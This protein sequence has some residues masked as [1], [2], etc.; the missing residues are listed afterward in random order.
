MRDLFKQTAIE[1]RLLDEAKERYEASLETERSAHAAVETSK[2]QRMAKEAQIEKADADVLATKAEADVA[3]ADWERSK[4]MVEFATIYPTFDGKVTQRSLFPGD[5]VRAASS[6]THLPLLTIERTDRF[7]I[8]VQIP[9]QDAPYADDNDPAFVKL[10]AL[11]GQ[12]FK[13]KISRIAGAEDPQI[14]LMR[15]EIDLENKTG[16]IRPGMYGKAI[17][18]LEKSNDPMTMPLASLVGPT[19]DNR[20]QVYV[21]RG[22][23]AVLVPVELGMSNGTRIGVRGGLTV[24]D[25]VIRNP[26]RN[27]QNGMT[28]EAEVAKATPN[29]S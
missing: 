12:V 20:G 25:Q 26:G 29:L 10:D 9:D 13:A 8:V 24:Q 19:K 17:I 21:V 2:A 14:R 16:K 4:V 3:K 18:V 27:L 23:K 6:G 15:V 22:G 7:R 11:P 5:F 28:V 1:E